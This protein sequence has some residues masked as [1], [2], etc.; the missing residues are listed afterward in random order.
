MTSCSRISC[1]CCVHDAR[2]EIMR[3]FS[4]TSICCGSSAW[5][6]FCLRQRRRLTNALPG[7]PAPPS[8]TPALSLSLCISF[9]F[10]A[11]GQQLAWHD[12]FVI[13]NHKKLICASI[14]NSHTCHTSPNPPCPARCGYQCVALNTCA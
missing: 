14:S 11:L 6:R 9:P 3:I 2:F 7:N 10:D 12:N 5:F 4:S 1:S 13:N 8:A